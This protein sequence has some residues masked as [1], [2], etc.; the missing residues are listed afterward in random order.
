MLKSVIKYVA[1]LFGCLVAIFLCFYF[2]LI[3]QTT[4]QGDITWY[5]CYRPAYV[6]WFIIPPPV[7]LQCTTIRVP[8]DYTKPDGKSFTLP[9]TRLPSKNPHPIGELLILD[10][11]PGAHSLDA[12]MFLFDDY[13]QTVKDNFNLL[14]YAPRGVGASHP[15]IDCGG[16][17]EMDDTGKTNAKAYMDACMQ[18]TGAD[19]LPFISSKEVVKDLD[20][21][22]SQLGVA[23]WSMVGYSYGTKLVAKYAEHYPQHLRAGVM[24]G[25][26]DTS[27]DLFTILNNQYKGAQLAFDAFMKSCQDS[28]IFDQTGDPNAAF[29]A[30]LTE[31]SAK[32]LTDKNGD[33]IDSQSILE[34]INENINEEAY[35]AEMMTML[36]ELDRGETSEFNTQKLLSEFIED[37]FSED[38]LSLVNC[39]DSAPKLSKD[40]YIKHAKQ[41][42]AQARYDDIT[43]KSDEDYL[44]ACYY[45]PWQAA[46]DLDENLI[47]DNTPNLLF[48]AQKYDLA[49][50]LANAITMA[51]RFDDTLIYTPYH[52]HTVSLSGINPCVDDYVV[53][54]LLNPKISFDNKMILCE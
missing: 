24:D 28:C 12:S 40:D 34:I 25:V 18:H 50:P 37:R 52:G 41:V 11:G 44:D 16:V 32:N 38:A 43:P 19:V 30:K 51:R 45:W 42:D 27:E 21:I 35:W 3:S 48:V 46:D 2:Y 10:G 6:S 31:I 23:T 20:N 22:R 17:E 49:T 5:S 7:R 29:I 36:S 8:V 26:V 13:G 1:L 14:G 47:T 39:A 53:Q 9:L 15:A 33:K 54:Y 4:Q